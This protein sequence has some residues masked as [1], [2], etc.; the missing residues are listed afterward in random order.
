M[1]YN[2]IKDHKAV[3]YAK[4]K[5]LAIN[6]YPKNH[7]LPTAQQQRNMFMSTELTWAPGGKQTRMRIHTRGPREGKSLN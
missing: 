2:A 5:Q 4:Q 3:V 6:I 7:E 1:K